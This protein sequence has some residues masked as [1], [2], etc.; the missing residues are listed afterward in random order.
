MTQHVP[1]EVRTNFLFAAHSFNYSTMVMPYF[2]SLL[3]ELMSASC[4]SD[5]PYSVF[6]EKIGIPGFSRKVK[7]QRI[8]MTV[9]KHATAINMLNICDL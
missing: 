7:M 8:E 5:V 4:C 2:F 9:A 6:L 1:I 3:F